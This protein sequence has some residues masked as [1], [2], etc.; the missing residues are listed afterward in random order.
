MAATLH[1]AAAGAESTAVWLRQLRELTASRRDLPQ[2]WALFASR[3]Q[4]HA[5]RQRL[6]DSAPESVHCNIEFFDFPRMQARLLNMAGR[7]TRRLDAA[8][9]YGVLRSL[10]RDMLAAGE[11]RVFHGIADTRGFA[12]V[13]G[14]HFDELK[15]SA[16]RA[17]TY[18]A[19]AQSRKDRELA[20]I[21]ARY[22]AL[23]RDKRL[24]D[25]AGAGWL[26][27]D[28]MRERPDIATG[29][30]MLLV[31]GFD[32]F[33][34]VQARLLA[35]MARAV[36][37]LHIALTAA[38]DKGLPRHS[39]IARQ[40]LEAAFASAAVSLRLA[41]LDAT[42]QRHPDLDA[43]SQRVFGDRAAADK[44][45]A[46][47][48]LESPSP[49][50]EA[51]AVL[52]AIKRQHLDGARPHDILIVLRDTRLYASA[53][54]AA[55]QEF[56]LPLQL[57]GHAP[58]SETPLSAAL[59][60]TLGL[61][62]R[63]RRRDLLDALR[64]PYICSGLDAAQIDLLERISMDQR[65][66]GGSRGDWLAIID[67]ARGQSA[68]ADENEALT[69]ISHSQAEALAHDLDGFLSAVTPTPSASAR[70]YAA[71]LDR[72]LGDSGLRIRKLARSDDNPQK[73][74]DSDALDRL[75]AI[76]R[77]MRAADDAQRLAASA[78]QVDW[79][80][81][82]GDLRHALESS[83]RQEA[84]QSRRG[85][86]LAMSA[87]EA[88]GLPHKHVYIL[89]LE[90]GQFP[91]E[92]S[93]DPLC[94]DSERAALRAR[95]IPLDP[96]SD[97]S[98]EQGLFYELLALPQESLTLSRP[99]FKDGKPWQASHFWGAVSRVFPQQAVE[100]ARLGAVVTPQDA[101]SKS[102]L[103]LALANQLS[104][105]GASPSDD[106]W[107]HLNWL[108]AEMPDA[109]RRVELGR[110]VERGRL[111]NAPF[112]N[113]SGVLSQPQLLVEVARK[114]SPQRIYSASQLNDYGVCG[115]RFF[116]KRLLKL[117]EI[118][119]PQLGADA[120]QM[121]SLYHAILEVTYREVAERD[122]FISEGNRGTALAIL[123]TVADKLLD[124]AP[125][126]FNFRETATWNQEK[127]LI[128]ARLAALIGQD[129]SAAS[130]LARKGS[131]RLVQ[132]LERNFDDLTINLPGMEALR[133]R[134][135]I[136]RVDE[137]DGKSLVIDYKLGS[138][139][140]TDSD[141][142][143]GRNVQML[144]YLAALRQLNDGE[145]AGGMFWHL[146]SLTASG[147]IRLDDEDNQAALESAGLA[148]ARN[149]QQGRGGAFPV[150]ATD[151]ENGK[152]VRYCEF[153]RLCRRGNTSRYKA[154][155]RQE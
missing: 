142:A 114:L 13:L 33:T 45:D 16:V 148:I 34:R 29:V 137:V 116:A 64:S 133:I 127:Q 53:L 60:D 35:E 122:L 132:S 151:I 78:A 139:P 74:R 126:R 125:Q 86:V 140:I 75:D 81:F 27:L 79:A 48:L 15:Q 5:F 136:D 17:S 11:L 14:R 123:D 100:S 121:G 39:Y 70:D 93:E 102:E 51:R 26:A 31:A 154:A 57:H 54:S 109:W 28:S 62:P 66:V 12:T 50:E 47:R 49:R 77:G 1:L 146:G 129:F 101:A 46:L 107:G 7:P 8:A 128:K 43:L 52:R 145:V 80:L 131:L 106:D 150:R 97:R 9:R 144:V 32:H 135:I 4:E 65:L 41:Q 113:Y 130:P 103:M 18:A 6:V 76:L 69:Q 153:A 59:L 19:A 68:G 141:L 115:F 58:A 92:M 138:T 21:Y 155:E 73:Q 134:G 143:S 105:V 88:R 63:F 40:R 147:R 85:K 20:A 55:G 117:E 22:Q 3:Q 87:H 44:S 30:D 149:I 82:L 89:G 83:W 37:Q 98:D 24:A 38:N 119:E 95:G 118:Q 94:L 25:S 152:C 71:W 91:A 56:G 2:V 90:E 67:L 104:G 23:L 99:A 96:R 84:G 108:R 72:L 42:K 112:D 124:N 61:A 10:A 120:L 110:A 36:P 111:S